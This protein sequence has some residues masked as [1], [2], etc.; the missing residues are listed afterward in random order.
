M[1]VQAE[2]TSEDLGLDLDA[3][4]AGRFAEVRRWRDKGRVKRKRVETQCIVRPWKA[5]RNFKDD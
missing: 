1:I 5:R 3:S 4:E 2:C